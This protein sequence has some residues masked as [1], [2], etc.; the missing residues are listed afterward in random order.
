[1]GGYQE[2]KMK[3]KV[4]LRNHFELLWYHLLGTLLA[5]IA[6]LLFNDGDFILILIGWWALLTIPVVFLHVEYYLKNSKYEIDIDSRKIILVR[7][8]YVRE[9]QVGE[10]QKVV[11]VR[12]ANIDKS[13]I[14]VSGWEPYHYARIIM[15]NGEEIIITSLLIYK[16]DKMVALLGKV[17]IEKHKSMFCTLLW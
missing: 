12:S 6:G 16:I 7:N 15:N 9:Y 4:R 14:K 10:V 17:P 2:D 5:I 13:R 11:L 3:L 8:N 1:M